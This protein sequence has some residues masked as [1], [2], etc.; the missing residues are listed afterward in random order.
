MRIILVDDNPS[1]LYC[2]KSYL[3]TKLGYE[4]VAVFS[5][6]EEFLNTSDYLYCDIVL[7]DLRMPKIDGI[8]ASKLIKSQN[9][10]LKIIAMPENS[11]DADLMEI[12]GAGCMGCVFKNAIFTELKKTIDFVNNGK[13]HY[14]E[15]MLH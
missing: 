8:L 1:F 6:G 2:L 10:D 4:V 9:R 13:Y 14:P 5:N 7:M 12:M 11:D 3:E 15:S